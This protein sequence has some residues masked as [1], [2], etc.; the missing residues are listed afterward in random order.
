MVDQFMVN[1]VIIKEILDCKKRCIVSILFMKP[2]YDQRNINY[3]EP[4]R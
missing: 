1:V 3:T 4:F 2:Y